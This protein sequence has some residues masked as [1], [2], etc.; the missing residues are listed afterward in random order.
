MAQWTVAHQALL[1]M[2]FSRKESWSVLLFTTPGDLPKLG[3]ETASHA[4][5]E[6]AGEFFTPSAT[7]EAPKMP[8]T[9]VTLYGE[10]LNAFHLQYSI[11]LVT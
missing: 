10:I 8:T 11:V 9:K 7:W 1:P 3:M 6:L 5:P 2:E 4:S